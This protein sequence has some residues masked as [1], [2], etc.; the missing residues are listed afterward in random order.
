VDRDTPCTFTLLKVDRDTPC[1]FTLLKVDRDTPF[2]FTLLKVDRDTPCT[3]TLLK[4][5]IPGSSMHGCCWYLL[6]NIEKSQI[7]AGMPINS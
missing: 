4:V 3:F 7:N 5:E 2:T 6:Y 1:T